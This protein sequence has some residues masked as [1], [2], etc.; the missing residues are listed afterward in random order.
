MNAKFDDLIL[1][2]SYQFKLSDKAPVK[3]DL[4]IDKQTN[5]LLP[6]ENADLPFWADLEYQQCPNCPLNSEESP[7]CPVARNLI[8]LID[9]CSLIESYAEM[10]VR[11]T[12]FDRVISAHTSAQRAVSSVLGLIMATSPC[13][14]TGYLKPMARFHVPLSSEEEAIY[15]TTSMYLLAQ[16]FRSKRGLSH[17]YDI[18]G[19]KT[20]Y[21]D[22]QTVNRAMAQRLK[23]ASKEDSAVNA[24]IL[25]EL[26]TRAVT[27]SIEDGLEEIAYLFES[28]TEES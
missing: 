17:A 13:P 6:P 9:I 23:A 21:H 22:L 1:N 4:R 16:Y 15:R 2:Y 10:D 8:P 3:I 26:L 19:L 11:I 27:W 24:V 14:F 18:N 5:T 28:Y 12:T 7:H 20:I 25:L